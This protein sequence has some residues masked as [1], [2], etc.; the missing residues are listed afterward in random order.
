WTK[1]IARWFIPP[2]PLPIEINT[3]LDARVLVFAVGV[4][5]ATALVFGL[6][7]ALHGSKASVMTALK[8]AASAITAP[9]HRAR[10]RRALVVAQVALSLLLLVSAGLFL[11]TLSNAQAADPGF[12]TRNG[13][14]AAIDLQPA[15][16]DEAHGLA[17]E[18]RL[19]ERAREI[20]GVESA[21]LIQ[22]MPLGF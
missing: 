17:F 3:T 15:G 14:L 2:A 1:D 7:P 22:R 4:T 9:A 6:V 18:Q 8:E 12:S 21:S 5:I 10:L 20:R 11:R 16:Y 19:L 13:L